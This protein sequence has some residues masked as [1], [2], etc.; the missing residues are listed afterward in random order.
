MFDVSTA[1]YDT[2]S[3]L[4][5]L[6]LLLQWKASRITSNV[7][8]TNNVNFLRL[9]RKFFVAYFLALLSDW[10]QGPYVYK[11]YSSYGF[12]ESQIAFLYVVG[13]ASSA[14][15]GTFTGSFADKF[16]RRRTSLAFC[17]IYA[18]CCL[19]KV[20][21]N[22]YVLL[23]GRILGGIATSMLFSTFESW[24]VYEHNERNAFPAEWISGTFYK[25]TFWNGVLAI[26]AGV[27]SNVFAETLDFGP[28]SPF[29]ISVPVLLAC[30]LAVATTWEE[31]FGNQQSRFCS[32]CIGGLKEV[33]SNEL[34]LMLG[35][36]QSLFESVM[37]MFVFIWTPILDTDGKTPLGM[38]FACFMVCIMVGSS[39]Y[40]IATS[41][42]YTPPFILKGAMMLGFVSMIACFFATRE[43]SPN[44]KLA[45]G[46]FL[47][48]EVAVG[49]Y[50]PAIGYLRS[51]IIPEEHRASIMNWFRLPTNAITCGGLLWMHREDN[52]NGTH[53]IF[54]VCLVMALCALVISIRFSKRMI[55]KQL[56]DAT[57]ETE[58]LVTDSSNVA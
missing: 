28:V 17:V 12:Q 6:C 43:S 32:L 39:I 29:I 10:L 5:F 35:I 30:L 22:F 26:V 31:N 48:L 45:F 38:V 18:A 37:Y 20:S 46:A 51:K 3:G 23:I 9:Q 57:L 11:L 4:V 47:T 15:F 13:F 41:G 52:K 19:T 49:M 34:I 7:S 50:F 44:D 21:P 53:Q 1:T 54:T 58:T 27:V 40:Q 14:A 8:S 55:S 25:S 42:M 2:F 16:G 36:V 56:V 33:M 24:Y